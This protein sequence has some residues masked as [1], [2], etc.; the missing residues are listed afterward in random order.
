[1]TVP[2]ES[3]LS[4]VPLLWLPGVVSRYGATSA[5]CSI[6]RETESSLK[7][8]LAAVALERAELLLAT[9]SIGQSIAL[10]EQQ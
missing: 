10:L 5:I 3:E 1:M 4:L 6:W 9:R 8:T 2:S 7:V